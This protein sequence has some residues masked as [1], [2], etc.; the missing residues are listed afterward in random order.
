MKNAFTLVELLAVVVILGIIGLITMPT[1]SMVINNSKERAKKAQIEEIE[2]A[3]KS[4]IAENLDMIS[5]TE[6]CYV[7]VSTLIESGYIGDDEVKDPT[8]NNAPLDECVII[9]Y[10]EEISNYEFNYGECKK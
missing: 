8:Q 4:W 7:S 1:V 10:S 2:K 5:E 9:T 6:P 3:A